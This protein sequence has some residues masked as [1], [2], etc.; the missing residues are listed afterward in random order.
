MRRGYG[1]SSKAYY[2]KKHRSLICFLYPLNNSVSLATET[3]LHLPD[4]ETGL[5]ENE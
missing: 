5:N 1:E 3:G 2:S 4:R